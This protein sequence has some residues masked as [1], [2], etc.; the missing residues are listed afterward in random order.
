MSEGSFHFPR[1]FLWGSATAAH[2][3]EGD[4]TNNNWYA[5]ENDGGHILNNDTSGKASDWWGGKWKD[6]FARAAAAGQNAHRFSI[7]WSRVQPSPGK[8]NNAA[9]ERYRE[10]ARWLVEHKMTPMVTLH[11]FTDPLWLTEKGGWQFDQ[12]PQLFDKFVVKVVEALKEYVDL[13]CTINEP[14]V[15]TVDG[16]VIGLFPPGKTDANAAFEVLSNLLR[17]HTLSYHTI[18]SSQPQARVGFAIQHTPLHPYRRWF[19]L[20]GLLVKI[21]GYAWNDSFPMAVKTGVLRF[22]N[23]KTSFPR[24]TNTMDY[25]GFNYYFIQEAKFTFKSNLYFAERV[26]PKGAERSPSTEFANTPSGIYESLKWAKSFGLPIYITENGIEDEPD[27]LRPR[28]IVEHIHQIWRA[29]NFNYNIKGYFHWSLVDNFEWQAGWSQ[30]FGLWGLDLKTQARIKRRS[31]DLYA[32]ICKENG[33]TSDMV[34]KYTPE[35]YNKLF[36]D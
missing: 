21:L 26:Y 31:G 24:A 14:N 36:P 25:L 16:Y 15:Y 2:Q 34:R 3:V 5:W 32:E 1:G 30:R 7:E 11:H 33:L 4:N 20:D 6:D 9:F 29:A 28:Y 12:A 35:I 10:M 19:P 8:W 13:W 23:K 17:A 18:H 22:L 27:T